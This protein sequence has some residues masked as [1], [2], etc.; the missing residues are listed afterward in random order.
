[1]GNQ[2]LIQ[3][4]GLF[5][6]QKL[7]EFSLSESFD[8]IV[9]LLQTIKEYRDFAS[10]DEAA[11]YDYVHQVFQL[12]GFNTKKVAQRLI[13][14]QEMGSSG[15][16]KALVCIIG[17]NENFHQIAFGLDWE[18]YLFYAARYHQVEWVILTNGLQFKVLNFAEDEDKQKYFKCELDE[19]IKHGK[20]DNFFTL[21]KV[22]SVIN[23]HKENSEA[24]PKADGKE[25][26]NKGKRVLSE[27]HYQR[28]EFWNQLISRS[29]KK[30]TLFSKTPPGVENYLSTGA[31]KTGIFY[32][33]VINYDGARIQLYIDNGNGEWNKNIFDSLLQS[34]DEIEKAYGEALVWERLEDNRA[35]IVRFY[36]NHYGLQQKDNWSNLQDLMIDTM[37]KF[38]QA[39]RPFIQA[40]K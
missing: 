5:V 7:F 12:F 6:G 32:N 1:M 16:P 28:K 33:Y 38:D 39:F 35:S 37:I 18:S 27:R 2:E 15:D 8:S 3:D 31:G 9:N 29:Q 14:L 25:P 21:Y 11:W 40:I 10:P 20:T 19:I 17:P 34:K 23:N 24:S 26:D 30:T 13:A 22:F 4:T 36:I